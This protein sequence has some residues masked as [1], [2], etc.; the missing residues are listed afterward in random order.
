MFNRRSNYV[1]FW[2]EACENKLKSSGISLIISRAREKY[3]S[4]VTR[5]SNYYI[6]ILILF[7]KYKLLVTVYI[8]LNNKEKKKNLTTSNQ[9]DKKI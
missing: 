2:T 1:G 4:R 3:I 5:Y 8:L 7:K 9:K 6:N